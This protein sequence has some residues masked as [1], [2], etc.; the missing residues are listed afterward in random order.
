MV[1]TIIPISTVYVAL[2]TSHYIIDIYEGASYYLRKIMKRRGE[3]PNLVTCSI[4]NTILVTTCLFNLFICYFN[5]ELLSDE[6]EVTQ[7]I[8][9]CMIGYFLYDL[10]YMI[11]ANKNYY[12][13]MIVHHNVSLLI[14]ILNIMY[15]GYTNNLLSNS[16]IIILETSGTL[17]NVSKF[18]KHVS[19]DSNLTRNIIQTNN[20]VYFITRIMMLNSWITT[21]VILKYDG[22]AMTNVVGSCLICLY[23]GS[24]SWF[25]KMLSI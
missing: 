4:F 24:I 16:V 8:E 17:T 21:A 15:H 13:M 14:L 12:L 3:I 10:S 22:S 5:G 23:L 19:K 18:M 7:L 1:Y 25:F 6:N 20:I 2:S 9:K 11:M